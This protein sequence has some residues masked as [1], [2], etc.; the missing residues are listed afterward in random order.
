LTDGAGVEEAKPGGQSLR[1]I[2]SDSS[3][4][5]G[6]E[7]RVNRPNA[8]ECWVTMMML[9]RFT[10]YFREGK[11][12]HSGHGDQE[13]REGTLCSIAITVWGEIWL[14]FYAGRRLIIILQ[15]NKEKFA[16]EL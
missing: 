11:G 4:E 16:M 8:R 9:A 1:L 7:R 3:P 2:W 15:G 6:G 5:G 10:S 12:K 13:R 14:D